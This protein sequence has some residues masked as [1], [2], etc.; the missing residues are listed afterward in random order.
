MI[1]IRALSLLGSLLLCLPAASAS[2]APA[3]ASD[4]PVILR[5]GDSIK[6]TVWRMEDM[7]GEFLINEA[8][9]VTLPL[10]GARKVTGVPLPE[11]RD[12]LYSEFQQK[13]RTTV[14]ITPLRRIYV[15]GEVLSPGLYSVD[16]TISLAGAIAV[17][18]GP[19]STADRRKIRV[20]RN[21]MLV[22]EHVRAETTLTSVDIRSGDEIF[23]SQRSWL[24]RNS[25]LFIN[26]A[27]SAGTIILWDL[28]R[29]VGSGSSTSGLSR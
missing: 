16:P 23:V 11:L 19:S 22:H 4:E 18:G 15:L 14:E 21:G 28:L 7:T 29:G 25:G 17:A 9:V 3:P 20:V 24:A 1:A 27:V 2:Q 6:L 5:P 10:L 26:L 8:G 12:Q 13:L